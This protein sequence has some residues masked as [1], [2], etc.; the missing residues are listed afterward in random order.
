MRTDPDPDATVAAAL[1]GQLAVFGGHPVVPVQ[2]IEAWWFLFPDAVEAVRPGTWRG[3]MPRHPRDVEQIDR[4]KHELIAK[5]GIRAAT[6]YSEAD[7]P[8]IARNIR[9]QGKAPHGS[10]ASYRRLTDLALALS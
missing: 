2:T 7:S 4:P 8:A 9:E 3:C 6:A 10:S 5:A 1:T